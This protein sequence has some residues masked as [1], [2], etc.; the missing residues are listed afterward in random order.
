MRVL[1][2]GSRTY[3]NF[4]IVS[5]T[6]AAIESESRTGKP[7]VCIHGDA[8]GADTLAARACERAGWDEIIA[9][10]ADWDKYGKRAGYV[11]NAQMLA[12]GMPDLVVAFRSE[13]ESRGTDMMCALAKD[14]GV[15]VRVVR[16]H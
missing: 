2:C 4:A 10:P 6:V 12:A 3:T 15:E 5:Q 7:L 1:F 9:F 14:A 11:R 16:A 13:G 8:R